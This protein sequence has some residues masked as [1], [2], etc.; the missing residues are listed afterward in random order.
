MPVKKRS[1]VDEAI[2]Y[3]SE[4][5]GELTHKSVP[6]SEKPVKRHREY[7]HNSELNQTFKR[8]VAAYKFGEPS[9]DTIIR[10]LGQ[11]DGGLLAYLDEELYTA[12][13]RIGEDYYGLSDDE[14][15]ERLAIDFEW[16]PS[17]SVEGLRANFWHEFD[18]IQIAREPRL[19]KRNIWRQVCSPDYFQQLVTDPL[20]W[21]VW[22]FIISRPVEYDLEMRTMLALSTRRIKEMLMIPIYNNEGQPR[23]PKT[24]DIILKAAAMVDM[25]NKGSYVQRT[26][27]KT[28]QINHNTNNNTT[29]IDVRSKP[30]EDL[31]PVEI[32]ERLKIL[33]QELSVEEQRQLEQIGTPLPSTVIIQPKA[34]R[35]PEPM[36]SRIPDQKHTVEK[37]DDDFEV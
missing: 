11:E 19:I 10:N 4:N 28:L 3:A 33:E 21:P 23:D 17:T 18:R 22:A 14:V 37:K 31:N 1:A 29:T 30:I 13:S 8:K 16:H 2:E 5:R 25:R 24:L 36:M 9:K 6:Q 27:N 35:P 20:K 12:I 26:E 34:V 32:Q 15:R 7:A